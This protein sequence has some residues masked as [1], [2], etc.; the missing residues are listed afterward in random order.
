M[1]RAERDAVRR[2]GLRDARLVQRDDICVPLD[3]Q[4]RRTRD[5]GLCAIEPVHHT[6]LLEGRGFGRIQVLGLRVPHGACAEADDLPLKIPSRKYDA[7][8]KSVVQAAVSL[9]L[10]HQ[11]GR[12]EFFGREPE[13]E[14]VLGQE[15][16]PRSE[17]ELPPHRNFAPK[18]SAP[19][20]FPGREGV[21]GLKEPVAE[22]L[23]SGLVGGDDPQLDSGDGLLTRPHLFVAK[24][25]SDLA[26]KPFDSFRE[27]KTLRL[28][29]EVIDVATLMA[30]E[31]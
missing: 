1:A 23:G 17:S 29:N 21:V 22:P 27:R 19:K 15:V 3:Y 31:T 7:V 25:K 20:V 2:T 9:A 5:C 4:R 12:G 28:L 30:A 8:A 16:S 6:R 13:L 26:C 24:V 14:Q 10:A 11:V 18:A